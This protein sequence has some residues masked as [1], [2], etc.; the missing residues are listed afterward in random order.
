MVSWWRAEN[1]AV[2][3]FNVNN[4]TFAAATYALGKVGQAFN[5]NGTTSYVEVPDNPNLYP[6]AGSFTVDAWINTSQTTGYQQIIAHY[7]CAHLCPSGMAAS[8][9]SLYLNGDK[10]EGEI[11]D[12]TAADQVLLGTRVIADGQFHHVAMMRDILNNVMRLYV[13]GTVEVSATLIPTGTITNDDFEADPVTIGAIIQNSSN[14]CG[15]PIQFFN[16]RIDEVQYYSRALTTPEIAGIFNAGSTGQCTPS[17]S[18]TVTYGNALGNPTPPRFV[19][20]VLISGAGSIP[21]S[22][23]TAGLGATAGQYSLTG[24]GAGAYTITPTKTG[25]VNGAISSF[26]AGKIALHVAGPPNPQLSG[27]QLVVADVSGNGVISSF[28]AAMIAKF[29]AGPPYIAPGIGTTGT[30][31]FTPVN[32]SYASI[33]GN[34]TSEDYSALLMGEVSGNW[35]NTGARPVV[36]GQ[37]A[38]GSGK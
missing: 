34:V 10:L 4:G 36:G 33:T 9:Y 12:S 2:D 13:D 31:R 1:D 16:G 28:D 8:V 11:R 22:V 32:R 7:E 24:F 27:N 17:I 37:V 29:V 26:D 35:A 3:Y 23:F 18:G 6:Q 14:G 15:C 20:N 30:W 5:L 38:L 19:S 21:V 25:G